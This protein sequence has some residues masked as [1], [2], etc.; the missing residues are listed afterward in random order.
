MS[1]YKSQ[2]N[3]HFYHK[4]TGSITIS[5]DL[6]DQNQPGDNNIIVIGNLASF[7]TCSHLQYLMLSVCKYGGGRSGRFGHVHSSGRQRVDTQRVVPN[8]EP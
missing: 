2:Y 8:E 4:R 6:V 1:N 3:R 7:P 5:T